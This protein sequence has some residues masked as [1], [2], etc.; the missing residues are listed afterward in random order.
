MTQ[1]EAVLF[2]LDGTLV[3]YKR[4]PGEV[5]E[6]A[7]DAVGC[8]SLFSVEDYY[9]RYDE[10]AEKCA[11]MEELRSDCFA[12]LAAANGY[13]RQRGRAVANAFNEERDQTR[14]E[15][16]PGVSD[17][18]DELSHAYRL[19]IVTNGAPDAQQQKINAV[20][21]TQWVDETIIAGH[22]IS[23]KPDPE[24]FDRALRS[25]NVTSTATVHVGDS[26]ETDIAGATAAGI[27]SVLV[28]ET[29][30]HKEYTPT[31]RIESIREL[32][33]LPWIERPA[34]RDR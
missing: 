24:P 27:A 20:N 28:S 33:S 16:L 22:D 1:L 5:L 10:F 25:L 8:N 19:A 21:L 11:S 32:L 30:R 7:F 3:Q 2:D 13:D 9:A 6:E 18:L 29:D 34:P 23:P 15:L 26:P 31:Y 12:A 14:V 4:S 17:V